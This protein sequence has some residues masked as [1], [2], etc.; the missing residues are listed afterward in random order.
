MS[1]K[2]LCGDTHFSMDYASVGDTVM[3]KIRNRKLNLSAVK[4]FLYLARNRDLNSGKLH[5]SSIKEIADYWCMSIRAVR[6]AIQDLIDAE[7][8]VP[9]N[10]TGVDSVEGHLFPKKG[11]S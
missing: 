11:D 4:V 5:G 2:K 6:Y 9:P 3:Q 10:R 1:K 7:L 8:Y